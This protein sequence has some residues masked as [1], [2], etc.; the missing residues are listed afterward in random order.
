MQF[1]KG[2]HR[3]TRN[4]RP[5]MFV[6]TTSLPDTEGEDVPDYSRERDRSDIVHWDTEPGD[7][8][9]HHARTVHGADGN[10][11]LTP[12]P[13]CDLGAVLR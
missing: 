5:N 6:T 12:T 2:S 7:I 11:S 10:A 9:I 3:W 4:F 1:V 13:A 8:T